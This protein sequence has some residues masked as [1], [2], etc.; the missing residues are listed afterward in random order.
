MAV[1]AGEARLR[2]EGNYFG[3]AVIRC[4]RLRAI[5]HGGQ[6]LLSDATRDLVVD[7]L[8]EGASVRDLGS[9]RLKDLGRAERVW[10]LCHAELEADFPPLLSLD[11]LPNNLPV[12][13]TAFVSREVELAELRAALH[14][15][16]LVTLTG[17]G[18]CG[19]TCLAVQ[20]AADTVDEYPDG[21]WWVDLS[22]VT[23]PD[24]VP[25]ELAGALGLRTEP[26]RP[27]LET[28]L[29]D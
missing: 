11:R 20:L 19:K 26:D 14:T 29:L 15:G 8:A 16:R 23:E 12:Q 22:V 18:G 6:T 21:A 17:V 7:D 1:H 2:D 28:L 9:H 13:L 24:L 27:L 25:E 3:P 5:G 10:Q 4:A